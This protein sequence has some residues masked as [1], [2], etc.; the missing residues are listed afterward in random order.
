MNYDLKYHRLHTLGGSFTRTFYRF[1]GLEGVSLNGEVA[2]H[3]EDRVS[4]AYTSPFSDP[5]NP[6][7]IKMADTDTFNYYLA[8]DKFFFVDYMVKLQFFQFITLDYEDEYVVDEAESVVSLFLSTDYLQERIR[9]DL[10][11]VY[12]DD[13]PLWFRGRCKLKVSD[14]WSFNIGCNLYFEHPHSDQDNVSLEAKYE[15]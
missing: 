1:F 4:S 2:V 7:G 10:L 6:L 11:W 9:P 15:F 12:C 3:L 14:Y 5:T 13:G 8:L